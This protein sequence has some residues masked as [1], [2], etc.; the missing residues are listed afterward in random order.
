M[1]SRTPPF[2]LPRSCHQSQTNGIH[3]KFTHQDGEASKILKEVISLIKV[4]NP[5]KERSINCITKLHGIIKFITAPGK[6]R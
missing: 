1:G 2:N 3:K 4:K 5:N 6:A